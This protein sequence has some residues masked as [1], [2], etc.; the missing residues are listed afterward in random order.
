V[1]ADTTGVLGERDS[2]LELKDVLKVALGIAEGA[3]LDSNTNFTAVLEVNSQ[4]SSTGLGSY[5]DDKNEINRYCG[6]GEAA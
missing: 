2:I 3:T 1:S 5:R 4:V 6:S